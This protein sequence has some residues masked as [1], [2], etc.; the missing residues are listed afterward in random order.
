MNSILN[1]YI[2]KIFIDKLFHK[3]VE[4][5]S[6]SH[7]DFEKENVYESFYHKFLKNLVFINIFTNISLEEL[8]DDKKHYKGMVNRGNVLPKIIPDMF[9]DIHAFAENLIV[10]GFTLFLVESQKNCKNKK[11]LSHLFLS[12]EDLEFKWSKI[13]EFSQRSF[14]QNDPFLD[15]WRILDSMKQPLDT[16]IVVDPYLKSNLYTITNNL[17]PLL[18]KLLSNYSRNSRLDIVLFFDKNLINNVSGQSPISCDNLF[19]WIKKLLAEKEISNYNLV[20][21]DSRELREP[22]LNKEHNRFIITNY[23]KIKSGRSFDFL[24]KNGKVGGSYDDVTLSF[25]FDLKSIRTLIEDINRLNTR[26]Y[27][28]KT[29]KSFLKGELFNRLISKSI[30]LN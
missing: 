19:V 2:D 30:L 22:N 8:S 5:K 26:F 20:F 7:I 13:M 16:I 24:D 29:S 25:V 21:I 9:K 10:S 12:C 28:D 6:T 11:K 14:T 18:D 27:E 1:L 23:W 17:K 15:D 3:M 4:I